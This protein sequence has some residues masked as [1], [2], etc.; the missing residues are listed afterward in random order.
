MW[1]VRELADKVTNVVMNY[2]EIE[3]KVREATNDDPWGPTGSLMQELASYTFSYDQFPEVMGML[4]K[5]M[6]QDNRRNWRRTYKSL[7]LLQYLIKYGSERVITSAREHI[8]DLRS[9]ENYTFVDEQGKDM[10]IN[11]RHRAKSLIEFIQDDDKL[12]EERKKAKKAKDKYI[13]VSSGS[14]LFPSRDSWSDTPRKSFDDFEET[15]EKATSKSKSK[16]HDEE[17]S[18]TEETETDFNNYK[19]QRS[20][21]SASNE[22][23]PTTAT[24]PTLSKPPSE[25]RPPKVSTKSSEPS[26]KIDLGAA[27]NYGKTQ[28]NNSD[29]IGSIT[30]SNNS[31]PNETNQKSKDLLD[32]I[33][34]GIS[35]NSNKTAPI[36]SNSVADDFADFADFTSFENCDGNKTDG[37]LEESKETDE[38]ADFTSAFTPNIMASASLT[39]PSTDI[40][41]SSIINSLPPFDL[42]AQLPLTATLNTTVNNNNSGASSIDLL[43]SELSGINPFISTD[44]VSTDNGFGSSQGNT[45]P[46]LNSINPLITSNI[47]ANSNANIHFPSSLPLQPTP[48]LSSTNPM[49][50]NI[51]FGNNP[52]DL[53]LNSTTATKTPIQS[54]NNTWSSYSSNVNINVD[55]LLAAKYEKH[56]APTMNQLAANMGSLN[57][58]GAQPNVSPVISPM[59]PL[60]PTATNLFT[61]TK[62]L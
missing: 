28:A 55:N 18:E 49:I 1:K 37:K 13:G 45:N 34:S 52:T 19:T 60:N 8:Y 16:F 6:L 50:N 44:L 5:R 62:K 15:E 46:L 23:S 32:D 57:L 58:I 41:P 20:N 3:G 39:A 26:R 40:T 35:D 24:T 29:L 7:I 54:S 12:R 38:F 61:S 53:S 51:P 25:G 42:K 22:S 43:N 9:L 56:N 11:I 10:G 2:T 30:L 21:Q 17:N 36:V 14:I 47:N 33:F 48:L 27:A 31:E 59:S 4:W